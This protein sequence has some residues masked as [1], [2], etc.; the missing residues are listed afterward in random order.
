MLNDYKKKVI[1]SLPKIKQ[2]FIEKQLQVF[3]GFM[4]GNMFLPC[5]GKCYRCDHDVLTDEI[6]RGN[7]GSKGVTGCSN[8]KVSY[9]E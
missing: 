6:N 1:S 2:D 9:C 3:S 7:D 5:D 4:K 8:C